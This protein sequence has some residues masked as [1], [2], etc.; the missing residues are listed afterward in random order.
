MQVCAFDRTHAPRETRYKT[1]SPVIAL[2]LAS[3]GRAFQQVL[4]Q[5]DESHNVKVMRLNTYLDFVFIASYWSLFLVFASLEKPLSKPVLVLISAAAIADLGENQRILA[6][7]AELSRTRSISGLAPGP[8]G[9]TKWILFA[10]ALIALA[11]YIRKVGNQYSRP[12]AIALTLS[13]ILTVAGLVF[14]TAMP[15]AV[16]GFLAVI[17]IAGIAYFPFR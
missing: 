12:L 10:A 11:P 13:G 4:D 8:F 1:T 15:A 17:V 9:Y 14:P 2:E 5:G 3:S 6:C 7:L 16:L